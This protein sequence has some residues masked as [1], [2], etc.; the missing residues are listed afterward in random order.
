MG[1]QAREGNVGTGP[2][3][4]TPDGSPVE[5][6]LRLPVGRE[7]EVIAAASPPGAHLLELGCGVGRVTRPLLRRGFAVT[8]VDESPEMLAH[9]S[10]ARTVCS[11]I[12][13]LE[14]GDERFDVV[15][16]GSFL[17]HTGDPAVRRGL[18]ATCRRYVAGGGAV[19]IEREGDDWH[20]RV[21]RER[22]LG[23]GG[24]VR[25]VSADP[26][27]ADTS[28]IRVEYAIDGAE[29]S[30]TFLSH[31]YGEGAFAGALAEAGLAFDAELTD[32]GCWIRALPA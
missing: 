25:V 31:R 20:E 29:W 16:L 3:V 9:V 30:Q 28:R 4:I 7:P 12:E 2:G 1:G 23:N 27:D 11:P 13:T 22:E 21:P 10:G 32:D 26:V 17:V 15:V 8:A 24:V 6:W 5:W 19:L 14:L 18:L